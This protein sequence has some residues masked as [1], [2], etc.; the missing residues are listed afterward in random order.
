MRLAFLLSAVATAWAQDTVEIDPRRRLRPYDLER[1]REGWVIVG[2]PTA[3]FDALRG[4]GAALAASV[5]YNGKRSQPSFAYAPYKYYIFL[6]AG[7]FLRESRYF[8]AFYDMPWIANRPYRLTMRFSFR[9]E[10]QGQFWG[11]GERYLHGRLPFP[12]LSRYEKQLREPIAT[13]TGEWQTALAQHYFYITQGQGWLIGER[14]A[15]RG[16]LRLMGG[17]RWTGE[18]LH[19]LAGRTYTLRRSTGETVSARQLPTLIDSAA[20]GLIPTPQK[21]QIILG[22]W[23][24]R[25][26]LGGAIV[27]D[28]RDFEINPATGWLIELNHES[29]IP[30]LHTHKSTISIRRYHTW[31]QSP[32]GTFLLSGALHALVT[33]N[34]GRILPLTELQICTRWSDGRIINLISGPSALRAFRENRF[35][36]PFI[37]LLQYELRSRVAEIRILRQHF[38]GGP[39]IFT[40]IAAGRDDFGLPLPRY[41]VAGIGIG[42]RV[43]WNMTTVLR[44]DFAY[45]REGWQVNFTTTHP[46]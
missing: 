37:Y 41:V 42:G 17:L 44:A 21:L 27:W 23:Q 43:I 36:T 28:T 16:L 9:D 31:Y 12:S 33:A 34:Y 15:H 46:F 22:R 8:R 3:G 38:T 4:V 35:L 32:T 10:G 19:S 39:V 26:F 5:A 24:H 30:R 1:K 11:V 2:Y 18:H 25:L 7:G 13:P 29:A 40:D 45:G 6:Q 20:A 14:I